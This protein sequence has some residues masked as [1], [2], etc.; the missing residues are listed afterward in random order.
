MDVK[1]I[2]DRWSVSCS[3]DE[4]TGEI[5]PTSYYEDNWKV[6]RFDYVSGDL[7]Y[8]GFHEIIGASTSDKN[9]RIF[10]YTWDAE[11]NPTMIEGPVIGSW[12]DRASLGWE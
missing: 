8:K 7:I 9:W 10:K 12:D 11:G 5:K 4:L 2:T 6:R 1:R 3:Y